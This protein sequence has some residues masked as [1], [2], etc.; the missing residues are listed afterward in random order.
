[1]KSLDW[2]HRTCKWWIHDPAQDEDH[3]SLGWTSS[4][5]CKFN[6]GL[7]AFQKISF[8]EHCPENGEEDSFFFI[9]LGF[10]FKRNAKCLGTQRGKGALKKT[11]S[12]AIKSQMA[13][14]WTACGRA[15][16]AAVWITKVWQMLYSVLT[17]LSLP[18]FGAFL[19][20]L[21]TLEANSPFTK[22]LL[23]RI[24][25]Q[26]LCFVFHLTLLRGCRGGTSEGS[27]RHILYPVH[28]V[29]RCRNLTWS[30]DSLLESG[31]RAPAA[32]P[33]CLLGY[34]EG[35][36]VFVRFSVQLPQQC[37][38]HTQRHHRR[39]PLVTEVCTAEF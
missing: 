36:G 34:L 27:F 14:I 21:P 24:I 31:S 22:H 26:T 37:P 35:W 13:T 39:F 19:A 4:L 38:L 15:D 20:Q 9:R 6:Q 32:D 30:R 18:A 2:A 25:T 33:A 17:W 5:P 11:Q 29:P 16:C 12:T 7:C 8:K 1:M 28:G 3:P 23:L 10:H